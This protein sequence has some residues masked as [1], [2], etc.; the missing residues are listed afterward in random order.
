MRLQPFSIILGFTLISSLANAAL[1]IPT[2]AHSCVIVTGTFT[3]QPT[4]TLADRSA[5]GDIIGFDFSPAT[6]NVYPGDNSA[7]VVIRTNAT[8]TSGGSATIFGS[9]ATVNALSP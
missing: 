6:H 5:N 3:C 8:S 2:A 4:P 9:L 1:L 7:I